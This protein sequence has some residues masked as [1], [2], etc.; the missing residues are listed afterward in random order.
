MDVKRMAEL[1]TIAERPSMARIV[2]MHIPR[3]TP[4][5]AA[6]AGFCPLNKEILETMA[7]SGPGKITNKVIVGIKIS[8]FSKDST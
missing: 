8:K 7:K 2:W 3:V 6:W 4:I 1:A 5:A